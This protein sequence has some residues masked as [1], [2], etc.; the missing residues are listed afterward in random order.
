V[1]AAH[2]LSCPVSVHRRGGKSGV[3]RYKHTCE[4][5]GDFCGDYAE[6]VEVRFVSDED[7]DDVWVRVLAQLFDPCLDVAE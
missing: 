6:R 2:I 5:L 3:G 1:P 7:G 4:R